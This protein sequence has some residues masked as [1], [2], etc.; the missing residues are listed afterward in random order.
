M[1]KDTVEKR[2]T[3]T[4]NFTETIEKAIKR[5]WKHRALWFYGILLALF[6]GGSS[7]SNSNWKGDRG[8]T[9]FLHLKDAASSVP[10]A[11][12]IVLGSVFG[13]IALVFAILALI[14]GSWS[15]AAIINGNVLLEK[16]KEITR[17]EI[18]HTGKMT[19]WGLIKLNFFIPVG[20]FLTIILYAGIITA[21]SLFMGNPAGIVFG[22]A[23]GTISVLILIPLLIYFGI[24]WVMAAR[25]VVVEGV[26]PLVA[27]SESRKLLKG[28]FWMTFLP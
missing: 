25:F 2:Q 3:E 12:W 28:N 5:P 7:F 16:G 8:G 11:V 27:L 6:A 22:V 26:R 18:G 19:V 20:I 13:I 24:V 10:V 15:L 17:K 14:I 1:A 21:I 9:D 4:P 23:I